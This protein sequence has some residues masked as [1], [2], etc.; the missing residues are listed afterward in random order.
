MD[1]YTGTL[2]NGYQFFEQIGTGGFAVVY[3]AVQPTLGRDVAIK[4]ILPAHARQPH[5]FSPF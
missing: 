4:I 3:R 1:T 5:F 2:V